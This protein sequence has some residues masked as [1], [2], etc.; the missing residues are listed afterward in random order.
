MQNLLQVQRKINWKKEVK[1]D[2]A[3]F[4]ST[5]QMAFRK[6]PKLCELELR[7]GVDIGLEKSLPTLLLRPEDK[8]FT[9]LLVMFRSSHC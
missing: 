4:V 2:I 8:R 5:E 7:H 9:L 1:F 6:F 3:Y